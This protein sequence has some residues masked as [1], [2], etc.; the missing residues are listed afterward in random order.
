MLR[1]IQSP[2][3]NL[4]A[5]TTE[6][7]EKDIESREFLSAALGV[8][9]PESWPPGLYGPR[10]MQFAISQLDEASEQGWSFWYLATIDEPSELVG[11]CDRSG[12]KTGWLGVFTSQRQ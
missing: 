5:A 12:C 3:L 10:A 7:I 11:I 2:R 1:T 9:V 8:S 4:I 6:L